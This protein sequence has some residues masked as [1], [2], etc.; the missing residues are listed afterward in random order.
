VVPVVTDEM[1]QIYINWENNHR[2]PYTTAEILNMVERG[3]AQ[4]L[5]HQAIAQRIG[6]KLASVDLYG[7]I[8]GRSDYAQ[9][10]REGSLSLRK[11]KELM[12]GNVSIL[13]HLGD[14]LD[15][16]IESESRVAALESQLREAQARVGAP[17]T[18]GAGPGANAELERLRTEL[19]AAN[20]ELAKI[21]K[22]AE[23]KPKEKVAGEQAAAPKER[24]A[25]DTFNDKKRTIVRLDKG[26]ARRTDWIALHKFLSECRDEIL[27]MAKVEGWSDRLKEK[28]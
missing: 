1:R 7:R 9:A 11:A 5:D 3:V 14:S 23:K 22:R 10:I 25:L 24:P 20:Q 27:A 12:V 15:L 28:K 17:G 16:E 18:D 19:N 8:L 21:K 2:E 6:K 4:G 26:K 13:E